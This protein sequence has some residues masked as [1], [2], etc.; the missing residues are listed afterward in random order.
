MLRQS[1]DMLSAEATETRMTLTANVSDAALTLAL[2]AAEGVGARDA[3]EQMAVHEIAVAH[4]LAMILAAKAHGFAAAINCWQPEGRQQMQAIE[5]A[6][7]GRMAAR[8]CETAQR[9]MLALARR[10]N[11][12]HQSITIQ[13]VTVQDGGQA[14]VT[15]TIKPRQP[16]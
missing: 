13:H 4:T 12:G 8:L 1:P 9:G 2:D 16:K 15:G 14:M 3:L 11:G 5:A 10:R 7:M 6:R